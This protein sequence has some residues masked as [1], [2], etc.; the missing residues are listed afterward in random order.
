MTKEQ[1]IKRLKKMIQI[2]NGVIKE[3][4]KNGDIFAM[5]LTADLDTDSIAIEK[6]LTMLKE[7]DKQI[8][9]M[10]NHIATSDKEIIQKWKQG[11]SKN[12]LATMYKRQYNQEIK[13]IRSAVRHRHDGRY[14]SNYE[15]LAY[16]ERVIYEYI[17]KQNTYKI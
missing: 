3:A 10:A 17:K 16:V 4:R 14:I 6:V 11:L 8:D 9:L 12:Q 1:A 15:A 5:Q 2:N 7:K 13:I